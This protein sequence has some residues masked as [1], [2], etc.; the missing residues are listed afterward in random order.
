MNAEPKHTLLTRAGPADVPRP[1]PPQ[2]SAIVTRVPATHES[3]PTVE[4]PPGTPVMGTIL[5]D[6]YRLEAPL[7]QGGIGTV[8]RATHTVIGKQ[9]A[10]KL[11]LVD[12]NS[13]GAAHQAARLLREAQSLSRIHHPNVVDVIDH[14]Y[15][16]DGP[17][18]IA[19]ERIEGLS[20]FQVLHRADGMRPIWAWIRDVALQLLEGLIAC[21]EASIVHRD[22]KPEN[23]LISE[24]TGTTSST[25]TW[26]T[27]VDFG[28]ALTDEPLADSPRLTRAGSVFGT[29]V[30]MSPEQAAA[31][32]VDHRTDIYAFGCVLH[33]MLSGT[34]P[35]VGTASQVLAAHLASPPPTLDKLVSQGEFPRPVL[36]ILAR[37]LAKEPEDRFQ[38]TRQLYDALADPRLCKPTGRARPGLPRLVG[39]VAVAAILAGAAVGWKSAS[40]DGPDDAS[41]VDADA[42]TGV[43]TGVDTGAEQVVTPV[44]P[45][46]DGAAAPTPS[47]TPHVGEAPAVPAT[48]MPDAE[49]T[50]TEPTAAIG[51][52]ASR[53]TRAPAPRAA[54]PKPAAAPDLGPPAAA[55]SPALAPSPT[56]ADPRIGELKNPF[57]ESGGQ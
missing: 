47:A 1:Q 6:R 18:V 51:S 8:W 40:S 27:L 30:Y 41:A 50:Q 2:P 14:G 19:M 7:G 5:G 15:A 32:K 36:G 4:L 56:P 48:P 39:V 38:T 25:G 20:L 49:I 21:H 26:V 11:L 3:S 46:P 37:C 45:S 55:S 57:S 22:I 10:V 54:R 31:S 9:V 17:P 34:P 16:D 43:D 23:I 52:K 42:D 29:P 28:I 24:R 53:A 33:E 12:P 13:R 35:F 44:A